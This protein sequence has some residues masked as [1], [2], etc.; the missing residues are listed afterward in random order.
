MKLTKI[1][2]ALSLFSIMALGASAQ[3]SHRSDRSKIKQGVRSGEL[4]KKETRSLIHQQRDI[5]SDVRDAKSD[6]VVTNKERRHIKMDR[7]RADAN[8]YFK[9]HNRRDRN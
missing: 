5:R 1:F 9:K 2:A 4:T 6:G 8:I 7:K 3:S